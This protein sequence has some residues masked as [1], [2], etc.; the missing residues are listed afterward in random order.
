MIKGALN[1]KKYSVFFPAIFGWFPAIF[2]WKKIGQK[3]QPYLKYG[4][5]FL[6]YKSFP[7]VR[8][9]FLSDKL[10]SINMIRMGELNLN[11]TGFFFQLS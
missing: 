11:M 4:W 5:F 8:R 10:Q 3:T 6:W 2:L 9:K 1:N 7:N